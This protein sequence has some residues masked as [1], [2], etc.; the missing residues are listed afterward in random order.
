[1]ME[2]PVAAGTSGPPGRLT[3]G[4]GYTAR[5]QTQ[6]ATLDLSYVIRILRR[7]VWSIALAGAVAG[8]A[9]FAVSSMLPKQYVSEA[10][11]LV[12]S[13]TEVSTDQLDAY[14]RLAETYA[15]IATTT[16]VLSRVAGR[17]TPKRDPIDLQGRLEVRPAG[18]GI[19][20]VLA[21]SM[22]APDASQMA[23]AMAA[24]IVQLGQPADPKGNPSLATIIQPGLQPSAP[25][26]P[27]I[28]L[29]TLLAS[30]LG[31]AIGAGISVLV[32]RS[33]TEAEPAPTHGPSMEVLRRR[34]ED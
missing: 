29:N 33:A 30:V 6:E 20:R 23:N 12:G 7:S 2:H 24:E 15:S 13:L 8:A 27:N 22:S 5:T 18:Q 14:A 26:A 1:M 19:I 34:G 3:K 28:L 11:V 31:L 9:A 16:P 4:R 21:S 32:G 17:L 10:R 25:A